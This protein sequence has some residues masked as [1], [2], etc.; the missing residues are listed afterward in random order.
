MANQLKR[1][2]ERLDNVIK[3][4]TKHNFSIKNKAD[5]VGQPSSITRK[6]VEHSSLKPQ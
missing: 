2:I 4:S 1:S 3:K 5:I 6:I